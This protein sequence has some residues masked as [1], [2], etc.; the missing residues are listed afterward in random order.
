[1]A[2]KKTP[3]KRAP[4]AEFKGY[5]NVNLS[6]EQ[7]AE[8]DAWFESKPDVLFLLFDL[9]D[10]GYKVSFQE[11]EY[12]DGLQ[13]SLYAK[14]TKLDWSGWTLSA[15]AGDLAEAAALLYFKHHFV[16]NRDWNQ[17]TGRPQKSHASRG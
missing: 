5:L 4:K 17:F 12:N 14:S 3:R 7:D 8:F 9:I 16:C 6:S 13:V 15:W 10:F 2:T 1:M 11:D